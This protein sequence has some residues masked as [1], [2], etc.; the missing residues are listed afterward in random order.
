MLPGSM[1][2]LL[3]VLVV[4][5][6][7]ASACLLCEPN[8]LF[9]AYRQDYI[10]RHDF[11]YHSWYSLLG[12]LASFIL[13]LFSRVALQVDFNMIC[14]IS[15]LIYMSH[16]YLSFIMCACLCI[17]TV[18]VLSIYLY[19][20]PVKI[21]FVNKSTCLLVCAFGSRHLQRYS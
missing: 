4:F 21:V 3:V 12:L 17:N 18:W 20:V 5:Y 11:V 16:L 15:L 2:L 19:Y 9:L 7:Y 10:T 13:H 8:V 14:F 6:P 1:S